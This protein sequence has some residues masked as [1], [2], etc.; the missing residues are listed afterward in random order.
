M[1]I[2]ILLFLLEFMAVNAWSNQCLT[3]LNGSPEE[4][5]YKYEG[6][7]KFHNIE[8]F[9]QNNDMGPQQ[10]GDIT[11]TTWFYL[12]DQFNLDA[13]DYSVVGL[14][15]DGKVFHIF[16]HGNRKIAKRL[17][18][19]KI[20]IDI[21]V[22]NKGKILALDKDGNTEV[23]SPALWSTPAREIVMKRWLKL[24]AMTTLLAIG[25]AQALPPLE[26]PID[27]TIPFVN[28]T[29]YSFNFPMYELML[30]ATGGLSSALAVLSRY[31]HLNTYP[32][33]FLPVNVDF[34]SKYWFNN[35]V[36]N[37]S[38]LDVFNPKGKDLG[39]KLDSEFTQDIE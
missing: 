33:G 35:I 11:L 9:R 18:G 8:V 10:F 19:E 21:S 6:S 7:E 39:V 36:F 31:E 12:S 26:M 23:F 32:N 28:L 20:F 27:I 30:T 34:D 24:F 1:R 5:L 4:I 25:G 2:G 29:L 37:K 13:N 38:I 15:E 17:N 16:K 14:R 22:T 3:L